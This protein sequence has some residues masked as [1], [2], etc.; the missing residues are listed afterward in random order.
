[1]ITLQESGIGT[2]PTS[3]IPVTYNLDNFKSRVNNHFLGY[4]LYLILYLHF[5]LSLISAFM[6]KKIYSVNLSS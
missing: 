3:V 4:A 2:F 1:M 6:F 5:P